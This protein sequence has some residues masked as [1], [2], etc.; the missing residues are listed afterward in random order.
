V[1]SP[2]APRSNSFSPF[3]LWFRQGWGLLGSI[4]LTVAILGL[5]MVL[6]F[7]GTIHQV[8]LGTWLAQKKYFSSWFIFYEFNGGGLLPVF[9][10]GYTLGLLWLLNLVASHTARVL[11]EWRRV[12]LLLT[13]VGLFV[14]VLGQGLTQMMARESQMAIEV[15]QTASYS[16]SYRDAELAVID[17]SASTG[18]VVRA[19]PAAL[20]KSQK[21]IQHPDL[22]FVI[23]VK[24]FFPNAVLGR[25]GKTLAT[26]GVG[27]GINVVE[28]PRVTSDEFMDNV[29]AFVEIHGGE[30]SLG[31]WLVS[32]GIGAPQ[33][34]VFDGK[35]YR[36]EM[37]LERTYYPFT[38]HLKHF[39]HDRYPGTEIPKNFASLL[40]LKDVERGEDR[41]VLIYMNHPLRYRGLTFYQA[42]FGKGDQ[43]SVLQ[44]VD[45]PIWLTPYVAC[46]LVS[47]GLGWQFLG[48]LLRFRRKKT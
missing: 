46:V 47:L 41:D 44:V 38:L 9:P 5:M 43:L 26:L 21:R 48:G 29:S 24:Q 3:S 18:D 7:F 11:W 13:H 28:A 31:V 32:M 25:G 33:T 1:P 8:Q 37:R 35:T 16:E 6:I 12:G 23:E 2:S 42:S 39:T 10:G 19:I 34:F 15:G 30:K 22:P 17:T 20:L 27:V 36:L 45:N 14:L 40:H 4:E